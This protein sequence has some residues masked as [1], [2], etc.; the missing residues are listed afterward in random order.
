MLSIIPLQMA[1]E[2]RI[3]KNRRPLATVPRRWVL[4]AEAIADLLRGYETVRDKTDSTLMEEVADR[5]SDKFGVPG[6]V[7]VN[8]LRSALLNQLVRIANPKSKILD[9]EDLEP[10]GI[11]AEAIRLQGFDK[12]WEKIAP[13]PS[14]LCYG[15]DNIDGNL[16]RELLDIVQ[17]IPSLDKIHAGIR[18]TLPDCRY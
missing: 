17:E 4:T 6:E 3:A 1:A 8:E 12:V 2:Y 7:E 11:D 18:L 16:I 13:I 15:S 9:R 14:V 5:V 10:K